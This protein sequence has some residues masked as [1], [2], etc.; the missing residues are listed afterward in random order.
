MNVH[1][2]S[3]PLF[4]REAHRYGIG[5]KKC[6][7]MVVVVVSL[8]QI[9]KFLYSKTTNARVPRERLREFLV[10]E[11]LAIRHPPSLKLQIRDIYSKGK[12]L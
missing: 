8:L 7:Y 9:K 2:W 5:F 4:F 6:Y 1:V 3:S 10:S 12:P 11:N